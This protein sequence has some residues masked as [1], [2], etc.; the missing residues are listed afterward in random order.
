MFSSLHLADGWVTVRDI[1]KQR[2]EAELV[3]LSACETGLNKVF[4][5]DEIL[6]LARGFLTAGAASLIVSLWTVNDA[7]ASRL[8]SGLYIEIQCG[9]T[10]AASLRKA[11][12]NSIERGEHPYLW[13]PFILIGR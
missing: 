4:P 6:G 9:H 8:M 3:V 1:C 11:K 2:I 12:L 7:A 13:S 10:P 5:G